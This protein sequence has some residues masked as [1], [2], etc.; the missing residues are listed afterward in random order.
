MVDARG[1]DAPK[2]KRSAIAAGGSSA[3]RVCERIATGNRRTRSAAGLHPE[4]R[5]KGVRE[6]K[7]GR[8]SRNRAD[9]LPNFYL[10]P[11]CEREER[12][13]ERRNT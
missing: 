12:T 9:E 4:G 5:A 1:R 11:A 2:K 8:E 7:G 3:N 6:R 10:I 13:D